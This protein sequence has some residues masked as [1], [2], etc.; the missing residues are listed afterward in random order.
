MEF[1]FNLLNIGLDYFRV[2]KMILPRVLLKP[3]I[4]KVVITSVNLQYKKTALHQK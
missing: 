3:L 4:R 2:Y 1:G